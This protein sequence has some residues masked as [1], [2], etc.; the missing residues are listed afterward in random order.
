MIFLVKHFSQQRNEDQGGSFRCFTCERQYLPNSCQ[1][2]NC[3][4][5]VQSNRCPPGCCQNNCLLNPG[6]GPKSN[7]T[8]RLIPGSNGQATK[9]VRTRGFSKLTR[10]SHTENLVNPLFGTWTWLKHFDNLVSQAC[11]SFYRCFGTFGPTIGKILVLVY[12]GMIPC[13]VP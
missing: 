7:R 10:F 9:F 13:L 3:L 11:I 1:S 2:R 8:S 6:H 4:K 5:H 12:T